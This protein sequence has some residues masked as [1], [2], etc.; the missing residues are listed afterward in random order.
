M[1]QMQVFVSHSH[2]DTAFCQALAKGLRDAG[3]DVWY[4]EHNM[5]S[6]QLGPAIERE[7]RSRPVFVVVLSPDALRS[8]WVE[9]ETRWAYGLYRRDPS[10]II[11]PVTALAINDDDVWLFLQDFKRIE[12]VE[13]CPYPTEEA[14]R[15]LLRAL[16]LTPSGEASIST[17]PESS[18]SADDLLERGKALKAQKRYEEALPLFERAA[19]LQPTSFEAWFNLGYLLNE[20]SRFNEALPAHERALVLDPTSAKSWTNK[21][22]ALVYLK[23]HEE[24][25]AALDTA[26]G[27]GLEH[28]PSTET[29]VWFNKGTLLATLERYEEAIVAYK[30]V[31]A[32]DN[33]DTAAWLGIV[34]SLSALGRDVEAL[35]ALK[36]LQA[37]TDS[38]RAQAFD[39]PFRPRSR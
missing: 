7:L 30:Q 24:A 38:K 33:K 27:L 17:S 20:L 21:G 14:V 26:L 3:A 36:Q 18:E 16:A 13:L 12:A 4:D 10:R 11:L 2:K 19:Q 32:L 9:D 6:G 34:I 29:N 5:G 23:Q 39:N 28:D 25:L 22:A 31:L 37:L 35:V 15:R 8:Q 1:A